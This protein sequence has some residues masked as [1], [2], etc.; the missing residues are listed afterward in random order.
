MSH[1]KEKNSMMNAINGMK[2]ALS[3]IEKEY[4]MQQGTGLGEQDGNMGQ[5]V[6][7]EQGYS[8]DFENVAKKK[9]ILASLME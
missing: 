6:D 4:T 5:A 8:N 3:A 7:G 2:A 9:K 1:E